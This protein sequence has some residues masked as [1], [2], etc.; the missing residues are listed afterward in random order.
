MSTQGTK[1][2]G[3]KSIAVGSRNSLAAEGAQQMEDTDIILKAGLEE[4][5]SACF[6]KNGKDYRITFECIDQAS[7][8]VV[9]ILESATGYRSCGSAL[10]VPIRELGEEKD[11]GEF[12]LKVNG[13]GFKTAG[14]TIR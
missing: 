2:L 8:S 3:L 10:M 4:G 1:E 11:A 7:D 6:T 5:K 12:F 9:F 14:I 13:V